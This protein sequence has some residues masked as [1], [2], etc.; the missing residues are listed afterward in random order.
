[1]K[2]LKI[3]MHIHTLN[4]YMGAAHSWRGPTLLSPF[5]SNHSS[6]AWQPSNTCLAQLK[7]TVLSSPLQDFLALALL[8]QHWHK[9]EISSAMQWQL[10]LSRAHSCHFPEWVQGTARAA[11][12]AFWL[13]HN[14]KSD[15]A[16]HDYNLQYLSSYPSVVFLKLCISSTFAGFS[17]N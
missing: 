2:S 10:C 11:G 14:P 4:N 7:G 5:P 3:H 6:F 9:Q 13:Q 15:Q 16:I 1:M 8:I 12:P 17:S